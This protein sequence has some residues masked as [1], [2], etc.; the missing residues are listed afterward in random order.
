MLIGGIQNVSATPPGRRRSHQILRFLFLFTFA[1]VI[2]IFI[3]LTSLYR[4]TSADSS[5]PVK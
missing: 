2:F 4:L 3:P 5:G 1:F